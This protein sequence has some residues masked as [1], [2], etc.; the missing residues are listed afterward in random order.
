MRTSFLSSKALFLC[1]SVVIF[2]IFYSILTLAQTNFVFT[3]DLSL[4]A[5]GEDVRTLQKI[6]NV[7]S[8]TKV[9]GSGPGSPGFETTYFGS[10][11]KSA[12]KKFQELHAIEILAPVG[13][14]F[15]TGYVGAR[16]RAFLNTPALSAGPTTST[17]PTTS[18][19]PA[20]PIISSVEPLSGRDGTLVTVKGTNF[21][22]DMKLYSGFAALPVTLSADNKS[23][24]ATIQSNIPMAAKKYIPD[25]PLNLYVKNV[26]GRSNIIAFTLITE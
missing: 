13:L 8:L 17:P 25:L 5:S 4:G 23:F 6:L 11:T 22:S 26:N 14:I 10:L 18:P 7:N 15:G 16:T 21:T 12:V 1:F 24:Q 20:A 19:A 2:S 3:R 9:A